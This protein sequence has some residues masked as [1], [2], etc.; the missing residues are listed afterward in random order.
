MVLHKA[1]HA[2]G[3]F[4]TEAIGVV[5]VVAAAPQHIDDDEM[6]VNSLWLFDPKQYLCNRMH[7]AF[8]RCTE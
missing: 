4:T 7:G 3:Q 1:Q 8:E 5:I 6:V 2:I